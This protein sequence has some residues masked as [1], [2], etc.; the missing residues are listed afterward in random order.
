M[1]IRVELNDTESVKKSFG[2][3]IYE[4]RCPSPPVTLVIFLFFII[5]GAYQFGC[6]DT[7]Q[8]DR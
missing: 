3:D 8:H 5:C 1:V 4:P 2:L 6:W 7:D